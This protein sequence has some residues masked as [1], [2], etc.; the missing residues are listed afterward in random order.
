[1]IDIRLIKKLKKYDKFNDE[2]CGIYLI[3]N[4]NEFI[5]EDFKFDR[6][7]FIEKISKEYDFL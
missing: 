7:K 2:C 1:M 5:D 6:E 4:Y 3:E